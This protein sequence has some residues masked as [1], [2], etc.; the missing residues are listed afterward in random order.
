MY[1]I[2]FENV[3]VIALVNVNVLKMVYFG[4]NIEACYNGNGNG[5]AYDDAYNNDGG[6]VAWMSIIKHFMNCFIQFGE[7]V[8]PCHVFSLKIIHCVKYYQV[9]Y[10]RE[11]T[12]YRSCTHINDKHFNNKKKKLLPAFT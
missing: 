5:N 12:W 10:S 7:R 6:Y 9:C 8:S 2:K 3:L 11:R 1:I 4:E